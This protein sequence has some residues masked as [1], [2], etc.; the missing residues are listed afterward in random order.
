MSS[1]DR[2]M[3]KTFVLSKREITEEIRLFRQQEKEHGTRLKKMILRFMDDVDTKSAAILA[4]VSMMIV[5]LSISVEALN[6]VQPFSSIVALEISIYVI[7]ALGLLRCLSILSPKTMPIG[8]SYRHRSIIET[9]IRRVIY[10]RCRKITIIVTMA[11]F[12]TI[13]AGLLH[14]LFLGPS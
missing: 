6:M 12:L 5:V 3:A 14:S 1:L 7:A 10:W 13:L 9:A 4:H 11:Y 2:L 8:K